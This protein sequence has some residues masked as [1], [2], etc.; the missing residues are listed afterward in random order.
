MR[1]LAI[2]TI[3]LAIVLGLAVGVGNSIQAHE[4]EGFTFVGIAD[5]ECLPGGA[6]SWSATF[7]ITNHE[8]QNPF[9]IVDTDPNVTFAPLVD[10][11]APGEFI[12]SGDSASAQLAG[13]P[14]NVASVTLDVTHDVSN[15]PDETFTS[16]PVA[17][18]PACAPTT[19][20]IT[21]VKDT[22]PTTNDVCFAFD[23]DPGADVACLEDDDDPI[24]RSGLA[25][26]E[27]RIIEGVTPGWVLEDI[28]CDGDTNADEDEGDRT[29]I[30]DLDA[31]EDVTCTFHNERVVVAPTAIPATAV[32]AT[33]VTITLI[34]VCLNISGAQAS[35]PA[36]Q[37]L[38]NGNCVT[39]LPTLV[40]P[41]AR[42]S[43]PS[44]GEV[45]LK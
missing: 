5:Q 44:T 34:D 35:V 31:G 10:D 8:G 21:L 20:S 16:D 40:A 38:Q 18:P 25:P 11:A 22:D 39:P 45:G 2:V 42:I 13:I 1:K 26:G 24:V 6:T 17:R 4:E 27:Y 28:D 3:G 7:T 9:G 33:P 19:G 37:V 30:V 43:P 23:F 15:G 14:V 32:P 36:G 41:V 12:P 29:A